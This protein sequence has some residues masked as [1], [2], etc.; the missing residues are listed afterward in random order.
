MLL[1]DIFIYWFCFVRLMKR[2]NIMC[3]KTKEK[4][5][6]S[7][8]PKVQRTH[9]GRYKLQWCGGKRIYKYTHS[10]IGTKCKHFTGS[11]Y[12]WC[13]HSCALENSLYV[14]P[15]M[16]S[17]VAY[18]HLKGK[19]RH[20]RANSL[21]EYPIQYKQYC[22]RVCWAEKMPSYSHLQIKYYLRHFL[23]SLCLVASI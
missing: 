12:I 7:Y 9:K 8:F 10:K 13:I 22:N 6:V 15:Y 4:L 3:W 2:S 20:T 16:A 11:A 5:I 23:S 21:Y 19:Q 14:Y 1:F 17:Y 18:I